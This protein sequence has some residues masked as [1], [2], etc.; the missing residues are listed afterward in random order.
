MSDILERLKGWRVL[1]IADTNT[2]GLRALLALQVKDIEA[3]IAEIERLRSI[4]GA[5][6][7]G[8]SL[9]DIKQQFVR[10]ARPGGGVSLAGWTNKP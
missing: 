3:A 1:N 5:V 10:S 8:M 9:A 2:E 7:D 6:S 4:A